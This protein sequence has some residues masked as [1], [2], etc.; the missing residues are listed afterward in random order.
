MTE[1][2]DISIP[3]IIKEGLAGAVDFGLKPFLV[4]HEKQLLMAA[5]SKDPNEIIST[6]LNTVEDCIIPKKYEKE[7]D[8]KKLPF[9][10][11]DYM[12]IALRAKSVGDTL[13][14][15]F[16]CHHNG[17]NHV[18]PTQVNILDVE[19]NR[20]KDVN[21]KIFLQGDRL[22]CIMKYP[23]YADVKSIPDDLSPLEKKIQLI[24]KSIDKVWEGE[25][26][27]DPISGES[28]VEN[29][30]KAQFAKLEEWV[31]NFPSFH[32]RV[33]AKCP[34]CGF[35]HRLEFRDFNRFF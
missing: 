29:L 15:Q 28:F 1:T 6:V 2:F 8:V 24:S 4:K 22:G 26:V 17:C 5:Q 31:D 34:K 23:T 35:D 12:F 27:R 11:I 19:F 7:I 10:A 16:R 33:S 30:T 32:V 25:T 21:K 13:D 9:F 18:F 14:V 3:Y 20:P